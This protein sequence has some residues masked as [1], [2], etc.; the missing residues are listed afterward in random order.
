MRECATD[1]G[2]EMTEPELQSL[3]NALSEASLAEI[4]LEIG[5][6][7]GGTLCRL[8]QFYQEKDTQT[9]PFMVVDP[10][11]YFPN[12]F[13][14]ECRNLKENGIDPNEIEFLQSS[15]AEAFLQKASPPL[16]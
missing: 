16:N 2:P 9:P 6:A 15:S 4:H 13:E 11:Q 1:L 8:I 3:L 10:M 14:V 12:Q 7:A 5:T